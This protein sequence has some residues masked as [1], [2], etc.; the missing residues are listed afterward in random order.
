VADDSLKER[1]RK[2]NPTFEGARR[3]YHLPTAARAVIM[4][5]AAQWAKETGMPRK[6][7]VAKA[8]AAYWELFDE[9]KK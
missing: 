6:E 5:V 9:R 2:F 7:A 8:A 1:L 3:R 4:A